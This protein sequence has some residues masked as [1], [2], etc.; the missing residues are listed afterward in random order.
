MT[1]SLLEV[2][3]QI[4]ERAASASRILS[5]A[6]TAKKNEALLAIALRLLPGT[7]WDDGVWSAWTSAISAESG[8]KGKALF[9]PLRKALTGQ[10]HG[11]D[12][13]TLLPLIGYERAAKRLAG[14]AA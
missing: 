10:E 2:L 1:L 12:M 14:E 8:L 11:P 6:T 13:K 3:E 5:Q 9:M 4:G 7:D